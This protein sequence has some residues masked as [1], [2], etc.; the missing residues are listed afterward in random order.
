MLLS[1]GGS[2]GSQATVSQ[3]RIIVLLLDMI[4]LS[5]HEM[6]RSN[7][8][9][10]LESSYSFEDCWTSRNIRICEILELSRNLSLLFLTENPSFNLFSEVFWLVVRVVVIRTLMLVCDVAFF[11]VSK[12][13]LDRVLVYLLLAITCSTRERV[14]GLVSGGVIAA[15]E[16]RIH[17]RHLQHA[18]FVEH[19]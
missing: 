18:L 15:L 7:M 6:N 9:H 2:K 10:R 19:V 12:D 14:E 4:A 8:T 17:L 1:L 11:N 16:W 5:I 3:S 13:L